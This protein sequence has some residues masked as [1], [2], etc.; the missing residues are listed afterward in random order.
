M[1]N[2]YSEYWRLFYLRGICYERFYKWNLAEKDFLYSLE[3]EPDNPDVLN[4]LAYGWLERDQKL[5]T[6][7]QMLTKAYQANPDSY[8]IL[9]SL[10]W[11]YFKKINFKKH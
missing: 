2:K 11:A 6:A 9:D 3:I 10:A 4:Y 8:Y 1:D 7:M 5:E